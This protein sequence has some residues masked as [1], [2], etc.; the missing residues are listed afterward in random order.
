LP[1][2]RRWLTDWKIWLSLGVTGVALFWTLHDINPR[3]L[4]AVL[5][6]VDPWLVAAMVP[7]QILAL[8][9]RAARWRYLTNTI[10]ADP[11]PYGPLFRATAAG[12]MAVNILPLRIGEFVRPWLL[13][14]ETGIRTSAAFGTVVIERAIDFTT[15]AVIGAL[16]L[17]LHTQTLPSWVRTGATVLAGL[18]LIPF[19]LTL[20]VRL[21]KERTL[22]AASRALRLLPEAA[23]ERVLD[24][25]AQLARGLGALR[26]TH[27]VLMVALHSLLLWGVVIALPFALGLP[28]F[29]I[30]LGL[31][32]G[33]LATYTAL[34]FTALAVAAPAAPGFFGVY[35]FACREAL[36]LFAV[37]PAVAVGY[38]TVLHL[39]YW[40]PVTLTGLISLM[41][42]GLH[43]SDLPTRSLGKAEPEPH[44]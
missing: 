33:A 37:P 8:W 40:I 43:L 24:V 42:S 14:R 34:V 20:A 27:D 17:L 13:A 22:R 11:L 41:S 5:A 30:E 44:R 18:G 23:A 31:A 10:S 25:L 28:A 16:V 29:G 21:D 26:G 38:G 6:S 1:P 15:V 2:R 7:L 3:E 35:H 39:A 12:F 4:G 36:G 19:M 32:Q 9:V